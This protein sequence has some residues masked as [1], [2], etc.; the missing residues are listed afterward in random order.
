LVLYI[1]WPASPRMGLYLIPVAAAIVSKPPAMVFPAILFLYLWLIDEEEPQVTLRKCVPSIVAVGA[2]AWL[3]SAMTPATMNPG[4]TSAYA[5]RITQPFVLFRYFRTFFIPVGLNADTGRIPF[6]SIFQD[7]ALLGILFL[8]GLIALTV[9]TTRRRE[10]RP[11]AFGLYWFLLASFPTS[12]FPLAEVDNDHRM[13]FPFVGLAMSACWAAALW[14]YRRPVPRAVVASAC[15]LALAGCAY[16][17]WRRN[18][19]WR[20][21]ESLWNDVAVKSPN[22]G[23]GLMN[24]G[25]A[26]MAKG[27]YT[28]ALDYFHRAEVAAPNYYILEINLGVAN[29]AIHNNAEAEKHFLRAIQLAP[30]EAEPRFYF[31]E[32]LRANVRLP[33]AAQNLRI[34]VR[35][36]PTH[37]DSQYLLMQVDAD[38]LDADDLRATAQRTLARFPRDSVAAAWLP[39]AADLRPTPEAY[40][41]QS[42]IDYQAGRYAECIAAAQKALELRPGYWEAWNNIAAAWNAQSKWDEGVHA[43]EE[44][45][46][47]N[48]GNQLAANNL[49]WAKSH[50][51]K[52]QTRR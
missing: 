4:A 14:T 24:Y 1:Y 11:I 46:R 19:I 52:S 51:E 16:G 18:E 48:P 34:A 25:L 27:D 39:R 21:D 38:L 15:A 26:R 23:R 47:L 13:F 28:V 44:A 17:T 12:I 42:L 8:A 37:I 9:L 29:G 7:D 20:S 41:S 31:A 40:L 45:V 32:W 49:A 22:N 5:Y 50:Q 36:N 35:Q 43:A 30:A 33:E 2:L 3:T 10:T 6:S